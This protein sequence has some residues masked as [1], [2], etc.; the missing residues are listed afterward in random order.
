MK[1]DLKVSASSVVVAMSGC[2]K[3]WES[4]CGIAYRQG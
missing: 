3:Y 2:S 4:S 1:V